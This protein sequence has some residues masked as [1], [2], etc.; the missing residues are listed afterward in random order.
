[1]VVKFMILVDRVGG[2]RENGCM[3]KKGK[4]DKSKS[5]EVL[6]EEL[7]KIVSQLESGDLPLEKSIELFEKGMKLAEEGTRK[8]DAAEKKVQMLLEKDGKEKKVPFE[9]QKE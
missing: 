5:F 9:E 2:I 1:M 4:G 6:V 3:A 8:L 7:E